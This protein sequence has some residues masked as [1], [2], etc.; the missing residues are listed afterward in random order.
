[1]TQA[2]SEIIDWSHIASGVVG[3]LAVA[4]AS[5]FL[6]RDRERGAEKRAAKNKLAATIYSTLL[7]MQ[8]GRDL[9]GIRSRRLPEL[10]EAIAAFSVF[11]CQAVRDG[12]QEQ[13][14]KYKEASPGTLSRVTRD[15]GDGRVGY[16]MAPDHGPVFPQPLKEILDY[17]EAA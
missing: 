4:F 13:L 1:M 5:H 7:D 3:G 15:E 16:G 8:H 2:F 10:T 12:L 9:V 11:Q 6:S 14:K 17:V